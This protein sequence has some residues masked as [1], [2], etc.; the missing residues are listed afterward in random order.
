MG[1]SPPRFDAVDVA[2]S[3]Y[4]VAGMEDEKHICLVPSE[5][6][7]EPQPY[8]CPD[9]GQ[10]WIS[11]PIVEKPNGSLA[12]LEESTPKEWPLVGPNWRR[13]P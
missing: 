10:K 11:R 13:E 4:K 3:G 2:G 6:E 8:I 9:C 5:I 7:R 12:F 1:T